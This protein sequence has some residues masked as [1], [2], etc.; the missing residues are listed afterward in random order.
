MTP[1]FDRHKL[2]VIRQQGSSRLCHVIVLGDQRLMKGQLSLGCL[3]R[4]V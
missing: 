4:T 2:L 1:N 3:E